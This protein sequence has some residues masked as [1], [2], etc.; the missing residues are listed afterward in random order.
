[1]WIRHKVPKK[2][3]HGAGGYLIL[4]LLLVMN[5]SHVVLHAA[6]AD[7]GRRAP[8]HQA[9]RVNNRRGLNQ[10]NKQTNKKKNEARA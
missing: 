3:G 8:V 9:S 6:V 4:L 1:M 7:E 10:A 2:K 5:A